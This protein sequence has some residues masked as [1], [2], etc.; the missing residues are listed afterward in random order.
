MLRALVHAGST[1]MSAG[2]VCPHL[3]SRTDFAVGWGSL[4]SQRGS[5]G[6]RCASTVARRPNRRADAVWMGGW[7]LHLAMSVVSRQKMVSAPA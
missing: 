1:L 3:R 4:A 5:G 7:D 2:D 6:R